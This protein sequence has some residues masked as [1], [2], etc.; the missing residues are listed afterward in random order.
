MRKRKIFAA[1]LTGALTVTATVSPVL[2]E[3]YPDI[4]KKAFASFVSDLVED[5]QIY[6]DTAIA[7]PNYQNTLNSANLSLQIGETARA[8]L[9]MMMGIDS[10]W[11]DNIGVRYQLQTQD[12]NNIY[13]ILADLYLNDSTICTMEIYYDMQ[14]QLMHMRVPELSPDYLKMDLAN[15]DAA[16]A[17]VTDTYTTSTLPDAY[18]DFLSDPFSYYPEPSEMEELLNRYST[19]L[20]DHLPETYQGEEVLS[21]EGIEQ[22]CTVYE[23]ELREANALPMLKSMLQT[24]KEDQELKKVVEFSAIFSEESEN[25]YTDFLTSIDELL[26]ELNATTEED[27]TSTNYFTSTIWMDENDNLV[28]RQ[29]SM[30]E[31]TEEIP[32]FTWK[33]PSNG[34]ESATFL[35]INSDTSFALLGTGTWNDSMLSGTYEFLVDS[36]PVVSIEVTDYEKDSLNGSWTFS[37]LPGVGEE[38]YASLSSFALKLSTEISEDWMDFATHFDLLTSGALLGGLSYSVTSDDSISIPEMDT[39]KNIYD[40]N[41]EEE[42]SAYSET[43]SEDSLDFLFENLAE[44]GVSEETISQIL[45]LFS[46]STTSLESVAQNLTNAKERA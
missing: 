40:L 2:A 28:G 39:S 32:L 41:S 4:E 1:F 26:E 9:G 27:M 35:E 36:V 30:N 38:N 7:E 31:D 6:F 16:Y 45:S 10:S 46:E 3:S 22:N 13:A 29:I 34:T 11:A 20:F 42:L 18:Y 8:L 23:A 19:I 14:T 21:V 44:A 37:P 17:D 33:S 24:A 43:L 12:N 5:Y 15:M 25:V